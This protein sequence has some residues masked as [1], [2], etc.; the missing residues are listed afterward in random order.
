MSI[1][2]GSWDWVEPYSFSSDEVDQIKE[3]LPATSDEFISLL[4]QFIR[5]E[6]H[7]R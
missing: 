3:W 7:T 1:F 6:K 4:E 2:E 5:L